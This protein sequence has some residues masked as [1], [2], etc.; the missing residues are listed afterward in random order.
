MGPTGRDS[1]L[2]RIHY[3]VLVLAFGLSGSQ[4]LAPVDKAGPVQ[5]EAED[6]VQPG[7]LHRAS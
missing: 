2:H 6:A 1:H 5:E 7:G 4:I 3:P